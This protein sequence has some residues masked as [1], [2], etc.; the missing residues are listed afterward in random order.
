[1]GAMMNV[2]TIVVVVLTKYL[3]PV[4]LLWVPFAA[5]WTNFVLDS[6]DGDILMPLGV[7]DSIYQRIDKSADWVTYVFM[8]AAAW[9]GGWPMRRL[10][11]GLFVF[12]T[13]GQALFFITENE[14]VFF[15]FPNF[16]EPLF[17]TYATI[18]VFKHDDA[19]VFY[20]RHVAVI[21]ILAF[22]YKMQDEW[23]THVGNIDRTELIR[24][25]FT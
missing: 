20:Q 16:L 2:A 3:V 13:I 18:R 8:V 17:L 15:I 7:P 21:W 23:V 25:L 12:R 1:M 4:L 22:L 11:I 14:F 10:L 9:R 5:G 24:N 6:V 19:R